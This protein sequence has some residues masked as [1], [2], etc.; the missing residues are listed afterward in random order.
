[1]RLLALLLLLLP[2]TVSAQWSSTNDEP[3]VG[4]IAAYE[5][6]ATVDLNA[7]TYALYTGWDANLGYS[8]GGSYITTGSNAITIGTLCAGQYKVGGSMAFQG[9]VGEYHCDVFIGDEELHGAGFRRTIGNTNQFGVSAWGPS[10]VMLPAASVVTLKCKAEANETLQ[11]DT[12]SL[13]VERVG[14]YVAP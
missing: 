11:A 4:W 10:A 1:M 2:L 12:A 14:P 7:T 8:K 5:S 13:Y 3:C 6:E 9:T